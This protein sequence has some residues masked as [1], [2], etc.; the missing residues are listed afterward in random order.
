M[1]A[2][3]EPPSPDRAR[4]RWVFLDV[5][6]GV[7]I[8]GILFVNLPDFTRL[9]SDAVLDERKPPAEWALDLFVQTRFLPIF[10]FLFGLS[11]MLVAD[12]ARRRGRR[13]WLVLGCR[14]I[15]LLGFAGLQELIYPGTILLVFA[16]AGLLVLPAVVL[17]P[18]GVQLALG[19]VLTTVAYAGFGG[20]VPAAPGLMLLGAAAAG[21]GLPAA[22]EHAGRRVWIALGVGIVLCLPALA[23]QLQYQGDP[24]F[25]HAGGIAGLVMG[26]T[27]VAALAA[28]WSTR[29][30]RPLRAVFA[31]LGRMALTNY[32]AGSIV[33]VVVGQALGF[34]ND[35][36]PNRAILVALAILIVQSVASRWWLAR[37]RY[38]PLEWLWRT[39]TWLEPV[40]LRRPEAASA[41]QST[42]PQRS[43]VD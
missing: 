24:R 34:R 26:A 29:A 20:G 19:V 36:D 17:T 28:A 31:P 43:P 9:A 42:S 23:W 10:T 2:P 25:S 40:A 11:L 8:A 30:R 39:L 12:S 15:A 22:L 21:F 32:V 6:R 35:P 38:G 3:D 37:F 1:T 4:G 13:P 41:R 5:L 18:R 27:Y 7:A 16:V 33:G 14:L